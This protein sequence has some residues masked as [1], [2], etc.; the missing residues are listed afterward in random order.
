[1][2][3]YIVQFSADDFGLYLNGYRNDF[4]TPLYFRGT[5]D[6]VLAERAKL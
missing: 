2:R 4:G 3:Y 5:L 6:Q 1:M